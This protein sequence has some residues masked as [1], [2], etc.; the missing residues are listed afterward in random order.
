MSNPKNKERKIVGI[1]SLSQ[2]LIFPG[3]EGIK[4][5]LRLSLFLKREVQKL[6]KEYETKTIEVGKTLPIESLY[7]K[8]K[9][10]IVTPGPE[11]AGKAR[12]N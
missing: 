9:S 11:D 5:L 3:I 1:S 12:K 10:I 2:K 7:S 6:I 4:T 8:R